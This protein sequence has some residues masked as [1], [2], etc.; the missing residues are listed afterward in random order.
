MCSDKN[1]SFWNDELNNPLV[2]RQRKLIASDFDSQ[3]II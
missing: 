1:N 3:L 2:N